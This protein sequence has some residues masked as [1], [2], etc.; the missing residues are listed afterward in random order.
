MKN[1]EQQRLPEHVLAATLVK[2]KQRTAWFPRNLKLLIPSIFNYLHLFFIFF[3]CLYIMSA[4]FFPSFFRNVCLFLVRE[5]NILFEVPNFCLFTDRSFTLKFFDNS[6]SENYRLIWKRSE[7]ARL[8]NSSTRLT[9]DIKPLLEWLELKTSY[10]TCRVEK[11]IAPSN[12][13]PLVFRFKI[14]IIIVR[15]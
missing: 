1:L 7:G 4:F 9:C 3:V 15:F 5:R 14:S 2:I 6:L 8:P 11:R 10:L 12:N 13:T